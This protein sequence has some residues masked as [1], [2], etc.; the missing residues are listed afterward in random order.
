MESKHA[1]P[2]LRAFD[3]VAAVV[4]I[5]VFGYAELAVAVVVAVLLAQGWV[6]SGALSA[7]NPSD[8]TAL[9]HG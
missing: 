6:E 1:A 3:A 2:A 9:A 5:A 4:P 8:E 7:V